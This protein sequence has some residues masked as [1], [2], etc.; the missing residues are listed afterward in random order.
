MGIV[1]GILIVAGIVAGVVLQRRARAK[2]RDQ[3]PPNV[4]VA[5]WENPPPPR[6]DGSV[7]LAI[8][9]AGATKYTALVLVNRSALEGDSDPDRPV[10]VLIHELMH[11]MQ[12]ARGGMDNHDRPTD[13]YAYKAHN[14]PPF[15][16]FVPDEVAWIRSHPTTHPVDVNDEDESWLAPWT[17]D[18]MDRINA[19]AGRPIFVR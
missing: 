15:A 5:R 12:I 8:T 11:A 6:E 7:D 17:F 16:P 1:I 4:I 13:W 3:R 10:R 9:Y 2:K 18:A 14:K 19:A